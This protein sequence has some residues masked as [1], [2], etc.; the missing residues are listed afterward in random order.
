MD[1]CAAGPRPRST[2]EIA[3]L[4]IYSQLSY[5]VQLY[6][7]DEFLRAGYPAKQ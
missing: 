5:I 2:L 7:L 6:G 3:M 4:N 1:G